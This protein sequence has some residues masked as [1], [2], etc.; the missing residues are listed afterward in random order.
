MKS[1]LDLRRLLPGMWPNRE[2]ISCSIC[3]VLSIL[4]H[5]FLLMPVGTSL[6]IK[7]KLSTYVG[8]RHPIIAW[9]AWFSMKISPILKENVLLLHRASTAVLM[10]LALFPILR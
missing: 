7:Y 6:A 4:A 10:V 3:F 5:T 9:H 2:Y 8:L 1:F